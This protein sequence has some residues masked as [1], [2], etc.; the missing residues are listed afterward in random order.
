[1]LSV[2]SSGLIHHCSQ[3]GVTLIISEGAILEPA[4]VWFGASLY[5]DKFKFGDYVPVT[6]IVWVYIDQKLMKPAELYLPHHIDVADQ[7]TKNK[8]SLLTANDEEF[9][10]KGSLI[11]APNNNSVMEVESA[12]CKTYCHH[13]CSHCAGIEKIA[14]EDARKQCLL[15]VAKKQEDSVT[16]LVHFCIFPFQPAC[17]KVYK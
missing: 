1:M 6:P 2:D 14:Y 15:A 5:S 3:Y 7:I 13:F 11:F 16:L 17:R 9:L 12:L 4:T 8:L 10:K